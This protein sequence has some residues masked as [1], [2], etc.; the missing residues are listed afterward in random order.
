MSFSCLLNERQQKPFNLKGDADGYFDFEL[1]VSKDKV[2]FRFLT[3]GDLKRLDMLD[4]EEQLGIKKRRINEIVNELKEYVDA[5]EKCE[6]TLKRSLTT[7]IENFNKYT[8]SIEEDERAYSHMI[9]NKLILSI[10]SINGVDNRD[11]INEYVTYMNVR[12]SSALRKYITE[13]EP[14]LD[15]NVEVERPESL[16]G[17]SVRMFL[18]LDQFIFLNII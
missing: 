16:G 5:D 17:G 3:Y 18:T 8:E 12:D 9:T 1:P 14:G 7:G 11:Y 15:F 13:N 10:A 2:K 6:R 4:K